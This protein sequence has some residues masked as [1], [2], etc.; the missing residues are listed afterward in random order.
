MQFSAEMLSAE[1]RAAGQP[2]EAR[3]RKA[4]PEASLLSALSWSLLYALPFEHEWILKN[5][6]FTL[7]FLLMLLPFGRKNSLLQRVHLGDIFS[8]VS[9]LLTPA[10]K[11]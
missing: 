11:Y 10:L 5:S 6:I 3:A 9:G 4:F 8:L 1:R 2:P 7:G